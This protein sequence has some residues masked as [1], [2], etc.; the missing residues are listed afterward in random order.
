M[1][2]PTTIIEAARH[3]RTRTI[4]LLSD[5]PE[6]A[7]LWRPEGV[8][9][10]L[11]W[12]FGHAVAVADWL[13]VA[14]VT[15]QS[16]LSDDFRRWFAAG[17]DPT[18]INDWPPR[19]RVLQALELQMERVAAVVGDIDPAR[20]DRPAEGID[21]SLSLGDTIIHAFYDEAM[22]F[23]ESRLHLALYNQQH[24]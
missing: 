17:S 4:K 3:T 9:N 11:I 20:L 24:G 7:L 12:R 6:D 21:W 5:A 22:H 8:N 14:V 15:G 16:E 18:M 1:Y 23:G 13:C 10:P 19:D 2:D